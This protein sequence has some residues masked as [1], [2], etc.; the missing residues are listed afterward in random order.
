M[1][2]RRLS[3]AVKNN[4]AKRQNF[5]CAN[6]DGKVVKNAFNECLLHK[7]EDGSFNASGFDIDH[8]IEGLSLLEAMSHS[9]ITRQWVKI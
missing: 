9:S 4:I 7:Y 5:K 1:P 3:K 2:R 6:V 8:I